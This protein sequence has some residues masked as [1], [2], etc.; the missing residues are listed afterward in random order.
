M[1]F[2]SASAPGLDHSLLSPCGKMSKRAL[3]AAKKRAELDIFGPEGAAAFFE[4]IRIKTAQPSER[5]Y[6]LCKAA[7]FRELASRGIRPR[8]HMREAARLEALAAS[9]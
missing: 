3:E 1:A 6:L 2:L 8:K 9:L 4:G 5:D 7:E